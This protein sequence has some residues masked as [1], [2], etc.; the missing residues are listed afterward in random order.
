MVRNILPLA[1]LT[2]ILGMGTALAADTA[3]DS[4]LAERVASAAEKACPTQVYD[5]A[6]KHLF[7]PASYKAEHDTCVRLVTRSA[8]AKIAAA[9]SG[10]EQLAAK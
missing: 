4:P 5:G 9:D 2:L 7:Y 1:S 3:L 6:P 10:L 8:L